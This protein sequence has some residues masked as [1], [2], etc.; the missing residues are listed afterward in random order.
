MRKRVLSGNRP[1][2]KL[3]IGHYH[4][5]LKSW[6]KL[7]DEYDC[8]FFVADWHAL[9]TKYDE[10]ENLN[11]DTIDMVID[12]L[13]MGLDPKKCTI[14]RQS[15]LPQVA[16]L[17]LYLSM[18]TP[19]SWLERCPTYKEMIQE[20]SKKDIA[21]HGF[22]GY[23]VL[24]TADIVICHGEIVPVGE[25]QLPH[26]ELAR[27]IVR[28]YNHIYGECFTEPKA[29]LTEAKRVLGT[30]GRKMSKSYGNDIKLSDPPDLIKSKIMEMITDPA[31]IRRD[32]PGH[33]EVC[34]VFNLHRVY[35]PDISDIEEKC[36]AGKRGCVECKSMLA[37]R[38]ADSL[39]PFRERRGEIEK[40]PS[41]IL[42]VLKDGAE[43]A[44]PIAKKILSEVRRGINIE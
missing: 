14:Y 23:P 17:A 21:T 2:G 39:G 31:R 26:L 37:E 19:I 33:P 27:E 13:A 10:T 4:G 18:I 5:A 7:Q 29:L 42:S 43:K 11:E 16:E 38:V 25:D 6:I 44:A 41:L 28:R 12:W 8:F 22:L 32:D 20:I 1:T 34:L 3:H 24:Q 9:T 15:D 30:D 36:I 40:D 35:S